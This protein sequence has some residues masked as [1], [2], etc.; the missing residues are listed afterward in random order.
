[1]YL[2][3]NEEQVG[4]F[5]SEEIKA[6][7]ESG[8]IQPHDQAWTEESGEWTP[9]YE[10]IDLEIVEGE[11]APEE[12]A[13]PTDAP[14]PY[15]HLLSEDQDPKSV[16]RMV[17]R[18]SDLL[19]R[20]E[21]IEFIGIQKHPVVN[22][23]PAGLILTDKRILAVHPKLTGM[24]FEDHLWRDVHDV[25]ISEQMLTATISCTTTDKSILKMD[26]LPKK[27]AR[28]IYSYAQ[29][30]EEEMTEVR[31]DRAMEEQ[32]A[33]ASPFVGIAPTQNA[34]NAFAKTSPEEAP[35]R[36]PKQKPAPAPGL[37]LFASQEESGQQDALQTSYSSAAQEDPVATLE[38]LKRMLEAGLIEAH[39]Y[40]SKKSEIL[41]RM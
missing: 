9:L 39:E 19:T 12:K 30:K 22:I 5:S 21:R 18:A 40:E 6:K 15:P 1:M 41:G 27:Q 25:H 33:G 11:S 4:P 16:I 8:E 31:R 3:Q 32:R 28:R 36:L 34:P 23:S 2:Y 37:D 38:Q 13:A 24:T 35:K 7:L 26:H 20:D 14:H 10:L 17:E 29:E